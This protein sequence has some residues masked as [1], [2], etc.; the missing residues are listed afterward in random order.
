MKPPHDAAATA[1]GQFL[2]LGAAMA[3][4]GHYEAAYHALMAGLHC[5]EDAGD[6]GR[7]VE[8]A[9]RL[10]QGGRD[11]DAIHPPHKLSAERSHSGTS[12]FEIG[13]L[14]AYAAAKLVRV[15]RAAARPV[16]WPPPAG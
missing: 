7:L 4:A 16:A 15:N 2:D 3:A 14:H 9:D 1:Y 6:A 13:A 10:R 12:L 5:A 11:V 8:V